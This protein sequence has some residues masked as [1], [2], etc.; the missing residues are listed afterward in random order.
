M[1]KHAHH[2]VL[3]ETSERTNSRFVLRLPAAVYVCFWVEEV[4]C[5][6]QTNIGIVGSTQQCVCPGGRTQN[7]VVVIDIIMIS[8]WEAKTQDILFMGRV[9]DVSLVED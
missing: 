5:S 3:T 8:S 9:A 7:Q 2:T 6:S 1:T 4:R